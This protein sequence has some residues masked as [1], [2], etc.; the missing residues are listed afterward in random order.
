MIKPNTAVTLHIFHCLSI[1]NVHGILGIGIISSISHY[2]IWVTDIL[3]NNKSLIDFIFNNIAA[4][5]IEPWM[6]S[7]Q[8]LRLPW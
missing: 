6:F 4:T 5:G 7:I 8:I 1:F 3:K 2:I